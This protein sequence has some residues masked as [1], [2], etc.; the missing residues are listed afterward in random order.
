MDNELEN[1]NSTNE[2]QEVIDST[3]DETV[4]ETTEEKVEYT[5]NEKQL[6]ARLKKA[7]NE[8]KTLKVSKK[9]ETKKKESQ[10]A[11]ITT[12]DMY[13]LI[14][15]DVPEEDFDEV[16]RISKVLGKSIPETLKDPVCIGVLQRNTEYRATAKAMNAGKAKAGQKEVSSSE[17][18]SNA[19]KGVVPAKGSKEAEELYWARRGGRR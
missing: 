16:V 11:D 10:D 2:E 12:R 19:S 1:L 13:V 17:I 4:D 3:N 9:P 18:L 7:E 15:A 5:E 8:L 14:K 6:Y